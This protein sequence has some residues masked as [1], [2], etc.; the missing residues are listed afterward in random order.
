MMGLD[1]PE[2]CRGWRNILRISCASS[3][4]FITRL[5]RDAQSTEH[6]TCHICCSISCICTK[7]LRAPWRWLKFKAET[8]RGI[9]YQ[10]KSIVQQ[11][12]VKFGISCIR[13]RPSLHWKSNKPTRRGIFRIVSNATSHNRCA[14]LVY[15]AVQ[16]GSWQ[17]PRL[18]SAILYAFSRYNLFGF[19]CFAKLFTERS[20]IGL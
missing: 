17:R 11:A 12:G 15:T 19:F 1:R 13:I 2:T 16:T 4:V 18:E 9:N 7:N 8:C 10:I 5:C 20:E 6:K 14:F 3:W